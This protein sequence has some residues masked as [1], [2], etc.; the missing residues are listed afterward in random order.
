MN[1]DDTIPNFTRTANEMPT[2][3]EYCPQIQIP[4]SDKCKIP[5]KKDLY[6]GERSNPNLGDYDFFAEL[7]IR[8]MHGNEVRY[9]ES[10]EDEDRT[11]RSEEAVIATQ[12][13]TMTDDSEFDKLGQQFEEG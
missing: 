10:S 2:L 4:T 6:L 5:P 13:K 7:E 1:A 8:D 11:E 9:G 12:D 3:N